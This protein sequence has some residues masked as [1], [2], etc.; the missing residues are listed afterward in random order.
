MTP[1]KDNILKTPH[2]AIKVPTA[3]GKTF[4]ACNAIHSIFSTYDSSRPKAVVWL[5]PWINLLQQTANNLS[6]PTHPYRQK[7]NTLFNH[8]VE[9]YEKESLLQG[10]NFNPTSVS[11]QVNIFVFNFSS[12]KNKKKKKDKHKI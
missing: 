7:L 3:G 10:T 4:I 5:V 11:E 8:S 12:L 6:D 2:I 1:Y 9:V